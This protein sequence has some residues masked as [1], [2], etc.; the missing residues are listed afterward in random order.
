MDHPY[1]V[2]TLSLTYKGKLVVGTSGETNANGLSNTSVKNIE[3]P[4]F[5]FDIEVAEIGSR[6][7]YGTQITAVFIPKSII[8]ISQSAFDRCNQLY[9]VRFEKGS[10]LQKIC[11]IAFW[12]CTSLK[13]IDFPSSV[14]SVVTSSSYNLF[15]DVSLDCFS[16]AGTED[17]S[18][19][20]NFFQTINKIYVSN[21]YEGTQFASKTITEKGKTCE[22]SHEHLEP[23]IKRKTILKRSKVNCRSNRIIPVHHCIYLLLCS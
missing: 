16:Y 13:R 19:L 14:S 18:T 22:T 20:T 10:K 5:F 17:F 2:F 1:L 23:V 7:F 11:F 8:Q 21:E 15:H 9:D 4:E 3:I 6:S 12:G